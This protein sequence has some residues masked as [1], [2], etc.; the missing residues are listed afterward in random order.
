[1]KLIKGTEKLKV[2]MNIDLQRTVLQTISTSEE[3]IEPLN[4]FHGRKMWDRNYPI[5]SCYPV[6]VQKISI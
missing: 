2:D 3:I 5:L 4:Q 1:M 6:P